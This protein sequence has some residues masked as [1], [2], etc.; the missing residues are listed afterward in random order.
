A[1]KVQNRVAKV[2]FDWEEASQVVP[3][4]REEIAEVE[5]ALDGSGDP[6][7]EM[8]DLLFSVVN[9]SRHL[10][11]DPEM[12]LRRSTATFEERFRRMEEE[13]PLEDLG[14][15]ELNRRWQAAKSE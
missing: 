8:G 1:A 13:G 14:L 12:A 11:I 15:E 6:E 4:L 5:A 2:G 3:K 9:L 7:A 10:G